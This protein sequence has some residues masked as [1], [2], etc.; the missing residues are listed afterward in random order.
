MA[1]LAEKLAAAQPPPPPPTAPVAPPPP[2][3]PPK[4]TLQGITS[5]GRVYEALING[6][7]VRTGESIEG[8]RIVAIDSR[9]VRLMWQGQDLTL[10]LR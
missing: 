2:P 5:D 7:T 10:R 8:A 1:Q 4:L 6:V 9:G 3:E